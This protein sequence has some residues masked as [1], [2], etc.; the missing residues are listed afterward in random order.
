VKLSLYVPEFFIA[1]SLLYP[2]ATL[3][4][5]RFVLPLYA[6]D[7]ENGQKKLHIRRSM[8]IVFVFMLTILSFHSPPF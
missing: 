5:A 2:S 1:F 8:K 7:V 6:A 4:H 3:F